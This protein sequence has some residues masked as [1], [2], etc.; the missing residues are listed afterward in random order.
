MASTP[1]LIYGLYSLHAIRPYSDV[2]H[3]L[4]KPEPL[5]VLCGQRPLESLLRNAE[6][7]LLLG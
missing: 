4:G 3:L 6:V 2:G 5:I 7:L 1:V